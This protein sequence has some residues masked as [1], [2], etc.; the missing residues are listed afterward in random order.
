[1]VLPWSKSDIDAT[2]ISKSSSVAEGRGVVGKSG[3]SSGR[4]RGVSRSHM[5][6]IETGGEW[7]D[8]WGEAAKAFV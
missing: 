3:T 1:M 4:L 5:S 2:G 8:G 7:E 6:M